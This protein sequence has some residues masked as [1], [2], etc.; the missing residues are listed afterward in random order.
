MRFIIIATPPPGTAA[1]LLRLREAMAAE[2][3]S[4]EA[5]RY[6]AHITLRTGLV[7]PDAEAKALADRFLAHAAEGRAADAAASGV[8]CAAYTDGGGNERGILGYGIA[9]GRGLRDLH[10]HLLGFAEGMKGPQG[11][12]RPHVSLCYGDIS[13]ATAEA[14]RARH[15]AAIEAAAPRWRIGSVEL[16]AE[17]GGAWARYAEAALRG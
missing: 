12:Y 1:P 17:S 13:P 14:L 5:A 6:P 3:G 11:D 16:W 8:L 9:L 15:L 4:R 10:G 2:T 7:C